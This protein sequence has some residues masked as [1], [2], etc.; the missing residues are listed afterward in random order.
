MTRAS[1]TA[2]RRGGWTSVRHGS[3]F[4]R[5]SRAEFV[6]GALAAECERLGRTITKREWWLA[7][8]ATPVAKPLAL[9]SF[10][11]VVKLLVARR[12]V[13]ST[14]MPGTVTTFRPVGSLV[15]HAGLPDD[16]TIQAML[17]TVRRLSAERGRAV[18]TREVNAAMRAAG[19]VVNPQVTT[20]RLKALA[21]ATGRVHAP[22]VRGV[23]VFA[24][25]RTTPTY[26]WQ[27]WDTALPTPVVPLDPSSVVR[28]AVWHTE[29]ALGR[30]V[31]LE[32][33]RRWAQVHDTDAARAF[34]ALRHTKQYFEHFTLPGASRA[35]DRRSAAQ[36]EALR[37]PWTCPGG[38]PL[39]YSTVSLWTGPANPAGGE[40]P[41]GLGRHVLDVPEACERLG[42]VYASALAVALNAHGTWQDLVRFAARRTQVSASDLRPIVLQVSAM[43]QMFDEAECRMR[44]HG[45]AFATVLEADHHLVPHSA[46]LATFEGAVARAQEALAIYRQWV[47]RAKE[48][49]RGVETK[50]AALRDHA[51]ALAALVPLRV[52]CRRLLEE[53]SPA[54]PAAVRIQTVSAGSGVVVRAALAAAVAA[55]RQL[56]EVG[57]ALER[58]A[59]S[60]LD[61]ARRV[62]GVTRIPG[63]RARPFYAT[64]ALDRVDAMCATFRQLPLPRAAAMLASATAWLGPVVRDVPAVREQLAQ[65]PLRLGASRR[66]AFVSLG[67]LGDLEVAQH[68]AIVLDD[69]LDVAAAAFGVV[70]AGLM[71]PM[72]MDAITFDQAGRP[73]IQGAAMLTALRT[74][75]GRVRA[76][77]NADSTAAL[78]V[79]GAAVRRARA[80]RWFE[81]ID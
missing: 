12:L 35:P 23:P 42:A 79:A 46:D 81:V 9:N 40:A 77:A 67:L 64:G 44:Q 30:P 54:A 61:V 52:L 49:G 34:R 43:L 3:P 24:P 25:G 27:P 56:G 37:T 10:Y 16:P 20:P 47:E 59:Y 38:E 60:A 62:P 33:V 7:V 1:E 57:G 5:G 17:E 13:T 6:H 69:P 2:L 58:R 66:A 76:L 45:T 63:T 71:P 19:V 4:R 26:Y 28:V 78:H 31:K 80:E 39:H 51:E 18:S 50:R 41:T 15:A 21:D 36:A 65:L 8:A 48:R 11:Q 22:R 72:G 74:L 14:V 29:T 73:A 55:R 32:E 70:C 68:P 53:A 75:E